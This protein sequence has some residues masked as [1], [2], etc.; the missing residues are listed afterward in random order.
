MRKAGVLVPR[1]TA[2]AAQRV[3]TVIRK[4]KLLEV[5]FYGARAGTDRGWP[6]CHKCCEPVDAVDMVDGNRT[7]ITVRA[8]HHGEEDV[9]RVDFE[10][11]PTEDDLSQAW[12]GM[13]FFHR[14]L[15]VR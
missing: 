10:S 1:P 8:K 6:L 2:A 3:T 5:A 4:S 11:E 12:R 15:A 14:L 9:V 7:S 13:V